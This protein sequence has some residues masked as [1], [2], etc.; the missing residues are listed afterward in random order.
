M[1]NLTYNGTSLKSDKPLVWLHGQVKTPPFSR[2]ARIEAGVLLRRLQRG[3]GLAL[4]HSRPMTS[5]GRGCHELRIPDV[6]RNSR[7]AYHADAIVILDVFSKSTRRPPRAVIEQCK[8]R[9]R[10]YAEAAR[11]RTR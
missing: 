9:L 11:G 7:I 8:A 5:I 3:E 4:P 1:S 6:N 10:S 2:D